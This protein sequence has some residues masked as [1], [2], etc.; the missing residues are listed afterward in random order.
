[1]KNKKLKIIIIII[2]TII[3][4]LAIGITIYL[5]N[6]NDN[7]GLTNNNNNNNPQTNELQT[8]DITNNDESLNSVKANI[9]RVINKI[10]ENEIV[11]TGFFVKEGYLLTNSH[12]VDIQGNITIEYS[13]GK[14]SKAKLIS[15]EIVSDV[16]ILAVD[17]THAL[18]L[19]FGNTLTIK[20]T[21]DL[22]AVG[23]ALNLKGEASITK[24]ILSARR[25]IAGVEYLQTDAAINSGFSGGPLLNEKGEVI[26]MNSLANENATIGM[27]ISVET[28]ENIM[29]KL[30]DN[31]KVNY[32]TT[33]RPTNALSSVL[34]ETGY[35]I[36]DIYNEWEYFHKGEKKPEKPKEEE[37]TPPRQL[38]AVSELKYLGVKGYDIGWGKDPDAIKFQLYF[39]NNENKLDL[40][41]TPKDSK[42]T[43]RV[44]DNENLQST[45]DGVIT[46]IVTAEDGIHK[47]EYY[48]VYHNVKTTINGLKKVNISSG[49]GR[50]Y[51]TNTN[52]LEY[53][54]GFLDSD[55]MYISGYH[56]INKLEVEL[57]ACNNGEQCT[58]DSEYTFLKKYTFYQN[59]QLEMNSRIE[60]SEIKNMLNTGNY[61]KDEKVKI[62]S[63]ETLTTINQG[64]FTSESY[65]TISQ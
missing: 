17:E 40:I 29:H 38:S 25:S 6:K 3:F 4:T 36:D 33:D 11:G 21:D 2:S 42:A 12:I 64:S 62:Y 61:F 22:Y 65:H 27:A 46:V 51:Q 23:Y 59:A 20:S 39:T 52:V 34:K 9:V 48:I 31:R 30:I 41:I 26:G 13:D 44:K 15:N 37:K 10:D 47:S 56:K 49:I 60:L 63:K 35:E 24:G 58:E 54:W 14:T 1:M 8:I 45:V 53:N 19:P 18:A 57:Y 50:N 5:I 16:A 55:G 32:L 28:L 7:K 43:Y